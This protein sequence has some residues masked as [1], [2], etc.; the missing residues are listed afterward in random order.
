LQVIDDI[1]IEIELTRV[2]QSGT[3]NA[4]ELFDIHVIVLYEENQIIEIG[5]QAAIQLA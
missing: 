3:K 4:F 5:V 1:G 2:R